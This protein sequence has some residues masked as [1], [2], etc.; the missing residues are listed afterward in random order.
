VADS[1]DSGKSPTMRRFRAG[2]PVFSPPLV[3]PPSKT[4][5]QGEEKSRAG[6]NSDSEFDSGWGGGGA[7]ILGAKKK[8]RSSSADFPN[9][10]STARWAKLGCCVLRES[11]RN[12]CTSKEPTGANQCV[13]QQS[14]P[15]ARGDQNGEAALHPLCT[16]PSALVEMM[17]RYAVV[18]TAV[19]RFT[20][21]ERLKCV[22]PLQRGVL[23]LEHFAS[24]GMLFLARG[25]EH[26]S[27]KLWDL[28]TRECVAT[29]EGHI[30]RVNCLTSYS[31]ANGA[32]LLASGSA[33][34]TIILWDVVAHTQVAR[35]FGHTDNVAALAVYRHAAGLPCLASGSWDQ[36]IKL[37]DLRTHTEI[38]TLK[39]GFVWS[40]CVFS[41]ARG[42]DFLASGDQVGSIKAWDLAT[43]ENLFTL[44]GHKD[45]VLSL[46]CFSNEDRVPM[47]VSASDDKTV[48]VWDLESRVAVKTLDGGSLPTSL[49]CVAGPDGHVMLVFSSGYET[50]TGTVIDLSTGRPVFQMPSSANAYALDAFVDCRSGVPFLAVAGK[51]GKADV[52]Q[53][54]TDP[55]G[56]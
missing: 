37:W 17:C 42:T 43:H 22:A 21:P 14:F 16:L 56:V 34:H 26:G 31:D 45:D 51:E 46:V 23:A 50:K 40:L 25:H 44:R 53:L 36:S 4:Q 15:R 1:V 38:A 3:F 52:I 35:L 29:L 55:G 48:K 19:V 41:D 24:D 9:S 6:E 11:I 30:A 47:L 7:A 13:D 28:S 39:S 20:H 32:P 54:Y 2:S 49:G 10:D 8:T 18:G 5:E 33:D 12:D 27:V